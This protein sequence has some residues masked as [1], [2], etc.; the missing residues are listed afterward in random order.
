MHL[1]PL[2]PLLIVATAA[3]L[4]LLGGSIPG[5]AGQTSGAPGLPGT[6]GVNNGNAPITTAPTVTAAPPAAQPT[7]APPT[8]VVATA[9]A[10]TP[11]AP[12]IVAPTTVAPETRIVPVPQA[13]TTS[14]EPGK[15][16]AATVTTIPPPSLRPG[17][18]AEV[19]R[20]Q[21]RSGAS[22]T[23]ALVEALRPLQSVGM[24][25]EEALALGMGQF[26]LQGVANWTDDWLDP[27]SGPPVHQHQGNDVFSAFDTPVRAPADGIVRF[28]VGGLGGNALYVTLPDGTYYYMAHLNGFN[29]DVGSGAAV[30]QGQV[31][32][33]NGDSGNAKGG[34]PHVHFEV[35]PRGGAAVDPK[36]FLDAWVAEALARAPDLIGS[37]RPKGDNAG[38][39]DAIEDGGV[40]Q[41]LVAT[42]L[43]RRFSAPSL[44]VP[45]RE[46]R[47]EGFNHA[48]LEPLTPAALVPL[49]DPTHTDK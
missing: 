24:T 18:V 6:S 37:F 3:A 1:K 34:T 45:N 7:G 16:P 13:P 47:S 23:G 41:I 30:K 11:V 36:P 15:T 21:Q 27:R 19:L 14:T 4:S 10:P 44:P 25:A 43:T 5:A 35:H 46:R 29:R 2:R 22:S 33:Y 28:E 40:P 31:L 38:A 12:T 48:V 42:G 17:Q 8:T 32:G 39:T 9:V 26:P 20:S 49:L